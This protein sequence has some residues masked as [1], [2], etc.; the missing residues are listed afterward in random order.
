MSSL[1]FDI[2]TGA[3]PWDDIAQFYEPPAKLG[4]FDP[5]S[6]KLGNTKDPNKVAEKIEGARLAHAEAVA[7]EVADH[8]KHRQEWIGKA[9]LSPITGRIL[10]IGYRSGD[11]VRIDGRPEGLVLRA[12]W[13]IFRKEVEAKGRLIGHNIFEFDLPFLVARSWATGIAVPEGL[14][15][16]GRYWHPVFV[17]TMQRWACGRFRE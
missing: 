10:A 17:D 3:R 4:P 16:K 14:L 7:S 5:A 1:V 2:E 6:V 13:D 9:A 12:F 11:K 15:D 8:V